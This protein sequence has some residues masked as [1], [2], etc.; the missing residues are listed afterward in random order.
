MSNLL[1]FLH[2]IVAAFTLFQDHSGLLDGTG[3]FLQPA[4]LDPVPFGVKYIY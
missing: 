1:S 3:G 2:S 4:F